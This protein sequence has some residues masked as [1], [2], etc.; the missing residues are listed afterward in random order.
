MV[1][2]Q[3]RLQRG[4]EVALIAEDGQPG[5][6]RQEL[7]GQRAVAVVGRGEGEAEDEAAVAV[8][9]LHLRGQITTRRRGNATTT[10]PPQK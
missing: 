1:R 4:V 10:S 6:V 3:L 9:L 5:L 2:G 8:K 7:G